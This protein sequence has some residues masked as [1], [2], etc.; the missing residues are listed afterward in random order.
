MPLQNEWE[1]AD[2]AWQVGMDPK[3][4]SQ[5]TYAWAKK[6]DMLNALKVDLV[7]AHIIKIK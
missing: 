4:A 1:D 7:I 6:N 2:K 3:Q 5:R